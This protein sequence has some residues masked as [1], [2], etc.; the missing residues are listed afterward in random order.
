MMYNRVKLGKSLYLVNLRLTYLSL[1]NQRQTNYV[2]D[3]SCVLKQDGGT[4]APLSMH[5]LA[6]QSCVTIRPV[7]TGMS[8]S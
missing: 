8:S 3:C 6:V 4:L 1:L 2:W 5:I 7:E